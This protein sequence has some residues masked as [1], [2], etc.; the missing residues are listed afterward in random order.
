MKDYHLFSGFMKC[1]RFPKEGM[2]SIWV[3][4]RGK[5]TTRNFLDE[6]IPLY[7]DMDKVIR[8]EAREYYSKIY[9][10]PDFEFR[11]Y[12][13]QII[14]AEFIYIAS[15]TKP[16][17][18]WDWYK[19]LKFENLDGHEMNRF[20][21]TFEDPHTPHPNIPIY[22]TFEPNCL[23]LSSGDGV[24][25]LTLCPFGEF[26][27]NHELKRPTKLFEFVEHKFLPFLYYFYNKINQNQES[28]DLFQLLM[29]AV[30]K[31]GQ[32]MVYG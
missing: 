4:P 6:K 21:I 2:I 32:F 1:V 11:E 31:K 15:M 29:G 7:R 23:F 10:N 27:K 19:R 12:S 14:R 5:I 28:I 13:T 24:R 8:E 20:L 17:N 25:H 30:L 9:C 26:E 22:L 3:S 16:M 18:C